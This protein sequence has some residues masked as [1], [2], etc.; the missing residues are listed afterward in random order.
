MSSK[1]QIERRNDLKLSLSRRGYKHVTIYAT[2]NYG[3]L[4]VGEISMESQK[5]IALCIICNLLDTAE[6]EKIDYDVKK[7]NTSRL[8]QNLYS[9]QS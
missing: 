6:A 5:R 1:C 9:F 8:L 4:W 7:S 3:F 2:V